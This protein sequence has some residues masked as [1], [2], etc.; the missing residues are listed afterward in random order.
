MTTF[1]DSFGDALQEA[2]DIDR[3]ERVKLC[4]K[5]GIDPAQLSR[6]INQ[7]VR[8]HKSTIKKLTDHLTVDIKEDMRGRWYLA[9]K[10]EPEIVSQIKEKVSRYKTKSAHQGS[11]DNDRDILLEFLISQSESLGE[12]LKRLR[13][14][15]KRKG[16]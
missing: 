7:G 8:P 2:L 6:Y 12:G 15:E 4:E 5:T 9:D 3:V 13:D 14:L 11:L 1:F 16:K 10:E